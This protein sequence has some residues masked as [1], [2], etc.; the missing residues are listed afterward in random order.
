MPDGRLSHGEMEAG[1]GL[2]MLASPTPDYRSPKHHREVCEQAR[3]WS[4]V[5]WIID[6]VLV[7]V[8]DLDRHFTQAKASGAMILSD[9]EEG[10]PARRYRAE[11]FEGHR[12]FFFEKES[13]RVGVRTGLCDE[14]SE[15]NN[16]ALEQ[17][18][19]ALKDIGF[20]VRKK[21]RREYTL[22]VYT[23]KNQYPLLNPRFRE[24]AVEVNPQW[25]KECLE[26]TVI[27]KG[28]DASLDPL[29]SSFQDTVSC[30][31]VP[32]SEV[33]RG[34]RY[35]GYFFMP[36]SF[37]GESGMEQIAFAELSPSLVAIYELLRRHA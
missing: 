26:V 3:K 22:R 15:A 8:D 23:R 21:A 35:H 2:I 19:E 34:Y 4:T 27:S 5:P 1:D 28:K 6:G 9:I 31:F 25:D 36:L 17:L 37:I 20:I 10:P 24:T 18:A 30:V 13:R 32:S 7:Y 12:W 11:D 33:A 29:L 14:G 16:L